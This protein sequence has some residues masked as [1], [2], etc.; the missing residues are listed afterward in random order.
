MAVVLSPTPM[1]GISG[2]DISVTVEDGAVAF[3]TI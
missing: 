1:V 2:E 3:I